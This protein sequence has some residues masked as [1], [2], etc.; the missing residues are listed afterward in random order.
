M[1]EDEVLFESRETRDRADVADF[2]QNL[3]SAIRQGT[4]ELHEGDQNVSKSLP[5]QMG[6]E[7]ELG[8]DTDDPDS[9]GHSLEIQIEWVEGDS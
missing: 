3:A 8:Q 5:D 2:L 4:L 1:S 7:V 9:V 6:I